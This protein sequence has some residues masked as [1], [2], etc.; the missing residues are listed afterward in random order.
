MAE[1]VDV[2]KAWDISQVGFVPDAGHIDLIEACH[3][4]PSITAIT[5][6][7]E[8]E[9]IALCAGAHLGGQR[10]AVLMQSS[11]VGNCANMLAFPHTCRIPM[12]LLVTMRG[13]Y[14]ERNPWQVPMGQA[15]RSVLEAMGVLV[16][17][18]TSADKL[19]DTVDAAA[20]MAFSCGEICAV[21]IG[22]KLI[23]AKSF[24]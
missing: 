14:G 12:L 1:L 6:T 10:G 7:S 2:L 8:E 11:G 19:A 22:Q 23:G 9:G 16:S 15:A 21:L 3:A 13:Q 24:Q 18:A 20:A 4:D 5:L 17:D